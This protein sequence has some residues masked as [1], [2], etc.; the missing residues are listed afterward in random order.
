MDGKHISVR[1]FQINPLGS[2]I[3]WNRSVYNPSFSGLVLFKGALGPLFRRLSVCGCDAGTCKK[4]RTEENKL[5]IA[6]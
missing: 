2:S 5:W 4:D 6:G 3:N 1:Y